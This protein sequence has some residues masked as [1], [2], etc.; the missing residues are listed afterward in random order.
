MLKKNH[1]EAKILIV[2]DEKLVRLVIST[3]LRQAGYACVAVGDVESAVAVLKKD[4]RAFSAIITDIMMGEMD[5]F[6][7]RDR[8][9]VV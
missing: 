4:P 9:S 3:K 5:G 8:K 2:D 6:V 7:F 1:H